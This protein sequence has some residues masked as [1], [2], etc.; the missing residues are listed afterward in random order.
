MAFDQN[1]SPDPQV[2]K[3]AFY[4]SRTQ[5]NTQRGSTPIW[6][7]NGEGATAEDSV[8]DA[9]TAGGFANDTLDTQRNTRLH[10][11][12][13][14]DTDASWYLDVPANSLIDADFMVIDNHSLRD[15]Y[16][17]AIEKT[18]DLYG[19]ATSALLANADLITPTRIHSSIIGRP[20]PFLNFDG[21]DDFVSVANDANLNFGADTDFSIECVINTSSTDTG[22]IIEKGDTGTA[23]YDLRVFS[24]GIIRCTIVD[25]SA[26]TA[27]IDSTSSVNDGEDHHVIVVLDRDNNGQIY[28]DGVADGAPVVIS[29]VGDIDAAGFS[30][31]IGKRSNASTRFFS[32]DI[33]FINIWNRVLSS[34]DVAT[35]FEDHCCVLFADKWGNQTSTVDGV[36]SSMNDPAP[37]DWTS[38]GGA[39]ITGQYDSGDAGHGTTMRIE[40]GDTASER[41]ELAQADMTELIEVD[42]SYRINFSYKWVSATSGDT[43]FDV[44]GN[45]FINIMGKE[46]SWTDMEQD[47]T[48]INATDPLRLYSTVSGAATDELLIDSVTVTQ[49][50]AVASYSPNGLNEN[51]SSPAV[52]E[53]WYDSSTN[54][55]T[56]TVSGALG[57]QVPHQDTTGPVGDYTLIEFSELTKRYWFYT[58][59]DA[60]Y[61]AQNNDIYVGHI[62]FGLKLVP[63]VNPDASFGI[64]NEYG[65]VGT[66]T[67]GG[68]RLTNRRFDQRKFFVLDWS[69]LT[70][71]DLAGFETLF[72]TVEVGPDFANYPMYF[73]VNEGEANQVFYSGRI[74][75]IPEI[76]ALTHNAYALTIVIE[77]EVDPNN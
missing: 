8:G 18:F 72:E 36:N 5:G 48:G 7:D 39:T 62:S 43:R 23:R 51:S 40:S 25:G 56:G 67:T 46:T 12:V 52:V 70:G 35:R 31:V 45:S 24:T 77:T 9:I 14:A 21:V 44:G 63:R 65:V 69:Y 4:A 64:S 37:G 47:F 15:S 66:T 16:G 33:K 55:L 26:N 59:N 34:G 22:Q 49:L 29:G 3:V 71:D 28:V 6:H 30:L 53:R 58:F 68:S 13:V 38:G 74:V 1:K 10:V 2:N 50:G 60:D 61:V 57:I 76:T 32:G 11:D 27:T 54:N 19:G 41:A 20:Q 75:G 42:K 17:V 73:S